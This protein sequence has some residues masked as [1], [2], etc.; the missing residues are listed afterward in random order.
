[1]LTGNHLSIQTKETN[2]GKVSRY[3]GELKLWQWYSTDVHTFFVSD[4]ESGAIGYLFTITSYFWLSL[5]GIVKHILGTFPWNYEGFLH[6]LSR[7]YSFQDLRQKKKMTFYTN[8]T[9]HLESSGSKIKKYV[10]IISV[11]TFREIW[12]QF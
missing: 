3:Q 6:T 11:Q 5:L 1:M 4:C 8:K 2:C 12:G 9:W 10:W 7:E